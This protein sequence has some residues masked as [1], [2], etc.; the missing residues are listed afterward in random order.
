M[1][2]CNQEQKQFS[3]LRLSIYINISSS[4]SGWLPNICITR[5]LSSVVVCESCHSVHSIKSINLWPCLE[6]RRGGRKELRRAPEFSAL[7]TWPEASP[8]PV[9][10][11]N[12]GAPNNTMFGSQPSL[13]LPV[14][15]PALSSNVFLFRPH[16][17]TSRPASVIWQVDCYLLELWYWYIPRCLM[18]TMSSLRRIFISVRCL[19]TTVGLLRWGRRWRCRN[20]RCSVW[21]SIIKL[22]EL[23]DWRAGWR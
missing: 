8:E 10:G 21:S 1:A 12:P 19:V 5:I 17:G 15:H 9:P 4:F 20:I 7:F 6:H 3:I 11:S 2:S 16:Y 23:W 18:W 22:G 14:H 13:S